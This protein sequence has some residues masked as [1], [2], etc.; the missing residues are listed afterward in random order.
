MSK[1]VVQRGT[2]IQISFLPSLSLPFCILPHFQREK[3]NQCCVIKSIVSGFRLIDSNPGYV[4]NYMTLG[5]I[6]KYLSL[7][8]LIFKIEI[9]IKPNPKVCD[10]DI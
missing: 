2:H 6:L 7:S 8:F 3:G 9:L 5:K 10:N 1:A 4:I